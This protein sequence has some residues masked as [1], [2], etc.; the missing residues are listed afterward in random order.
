MKIHRELTSYMLL[1]D[2]DIRDGRLVG[3]LLKVVLDLS[4][5]IFLIEPGS[6][7]QLFETVV[8]E[9]AAYS[10]T[11]IW[12]FKWAKSELRRVFALWQY[13]Q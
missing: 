6:C 10:L 3:L 7:N 9:R 1:V 13:G 8:R 12:D 5:V 4:A 2:E 11:Y